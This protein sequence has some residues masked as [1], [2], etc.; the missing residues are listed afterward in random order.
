[1]L[2]DIVRQLAKQGRTNQLTSQLVR[3]FSPPLPHSVLELY[4]HHGSRCHFHFSAHQKDNA[5]SASS[6]RGLEQA[7]AGIAA[8]TGT[9][10]GQ[11]EACLLGVTLQFEKSTTQ[12]QHN[13]QSHFLGKNSTKAEAGRAVDAALNS[14]K[15]DPVHCACSRQDAQYTQEAH[16]F[17]G[18]KRQAMQAAK[19]KNKRG[20]ISRFSGVSQHGP[21]FC[22]RVRSQ[23]A[24]VRLGTFA[25]EKEAAEA[26][27]KACI[28]LGR[29]PKNFS[30]SSYDADS[31][32]A[33]TSLEVLIKKMRLS[34][35]PLP[36][37]V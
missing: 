11:P 32:C 13:G 29:E 15:T 31:I 26:H 25:T 10:R 5:R 21:K 19:A 7:A 1:M 22:A 37:G 20:K 16:D 12:V 28:Y 18:L 9:A 3:P 14:W 4:I 34:R 35:P 17:E 30:A 6:A 8:A 36:P 33:S 27:D 2:A 24:Q 23:G